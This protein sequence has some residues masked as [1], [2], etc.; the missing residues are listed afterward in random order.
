MQNVEKTKIA[1]LLEHKG[2][3]QAELKRRIKETTGADIGADRISK[4]CTGRLQNYTLYTAKVIA[5][6]LG[7]PVDEIVEF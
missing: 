7:V 6:T 2:I 1:K 4:I 5:V 3:S